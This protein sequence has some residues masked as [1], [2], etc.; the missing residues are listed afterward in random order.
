M[1]IGTDDEKASAIVE[2]SHEAKH[3]LCTNH[4]KGN[5][6]RN[7]TDKIPVSKPD[8]NNII[9]QIFGA[10]GLASANDSATFDERNM[11]LKDYKDH[12]DILSN[13]VKHV[14]IKNL[15]HC[16]NEEHKLWTNNNIEPIN[17]VSIDW[18]PNRT[19]DQV[20]TLYDATRV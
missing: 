13:H 12:P 9:Q 17:K 8:K 4:I 16:V 20:R 3:R 10:N 15:D 11:E 6:N 7:M 1:R 18:K 2:T 5:L 19:G 14:E